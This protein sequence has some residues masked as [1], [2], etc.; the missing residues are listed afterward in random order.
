VAAKPT[1]RVVLAAAAV[2]PLAAVSGCDG[3]DVLAA[4]PSP[5]PDVAVLREAI[6]A[7][8]LMITRYAAVLH[9]AGAAGGAAAGGSAG[10][11]AAALEPLLAEHRAHLTQLQSRLIVPAGSKASPAARRGSAPA[12]ATVPSVAGAGVAFLGAAEQAAATAMRSRLHSASPSL[13][14]LFASI[15]ASEATHVPVL[16]AAAARIAQ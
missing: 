3:A 15:G 13:A 2:L 5:A 12:V 4:P 8:Q 9:E 11:L 16:D 6:A 14:Q 10:S 7:E 1:R